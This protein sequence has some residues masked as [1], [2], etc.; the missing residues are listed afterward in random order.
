MTRFVALVSGKGGVGKTTS[1]LNI[2]QSLV[3]LGSKVILL[4]AN[5]VTPNLA[6][7]L[8][9]VK[10][11]GTVNKFLRKEKSLK[12]VT[13]LH[14]SG[15]SIIPASPSYNEFQ[16]TDPQNL[17]EI[18][19]HLDDTVDFVL[20]DAP[21]GLGYE[22]SQV[23]KNTDEVIIIVNPNLSSV[24]DALK[25]IRLAKENNNIIGGVLLNMSNGGRYEL[26]KIE[27]EEILNQPILA[28]VK[29]TRKMRK[30]LHK[31]LPLHYLY[32]RSSAAKEFRKVAE[33]LTYRK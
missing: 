16:K 9:F 17:T 7:Q 6:I 32:P 23:L 21:S 28:N 13:Y 24:M 5:I 14:E 15:I 33:H 27:I 1:T 20:V 18:F 31:K 22:I 12:E 4:D 11:E 2:G 10:P 19:E 8:G 30:A 26:K 29:Y 25:T 3:T